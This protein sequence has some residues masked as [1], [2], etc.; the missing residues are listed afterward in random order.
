MSLFIMAT[1][2]ILNTHLTLASIIP[3]ILPVFIACKA[4]LGLS[5]LIMVSNTYYI[6][7]I[8]NLNLQF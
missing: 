4:A 7:Y 6:G 2:I 8:Q 1:L 3:I 5:L